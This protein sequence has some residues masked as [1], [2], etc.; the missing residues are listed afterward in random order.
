MKRFLFVLFLLA[1]CYQ[2]C[3]QLNRISTDEY[4]TT[5]GDAGV[6]VELDGGFSTEF[7]SGAKEVF[8][9]AGE[10][11]I[12]MDGGLID[13]GFV[14]AGI[15]CQQCRSNADCADAGLCIKNIMFGELFCSVYCADNSCPP[16]FWCTPPFI[17][18]GYIDDRLQQCMPL[19][20]YK[21]CR[22]NL[23]G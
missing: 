9:D 15:L 17:Y 6:G 2:D 7:D 8:V 10:D 18:G 3:Y 19:D 13:A 23:E 12:I 4:I 21:T 5:D 16:G 20:P 14:D 11:E 22:E 1:G